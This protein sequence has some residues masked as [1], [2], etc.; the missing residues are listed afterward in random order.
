MLLIVANKRKVHNLSV[1]P[2]LFED[3]VSGGKQFEVRPSSDGYSVGD[4]VLMREYGFM[5]YVPDPCFTGRKYLA[6]ITYVLPSGCM[7]GI[8]E[9][10]CIF[11]F[12]KVSAFKWLWLQLIERESVNE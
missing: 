12:K 9:D 4:I 5:D 7:Q 8:G 1:H 6:I 3:V 10:I 11:G 2:I